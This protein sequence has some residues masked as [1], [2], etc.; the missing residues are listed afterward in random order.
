[1]RESRKLARSLLNIKDI[2]C[3]NIIKNVE[4]FYK[5]NGRTKKSFE[6]ILII[7]SLLNK[8][9]VEDLIKNVH[10]Y[11]I[12]FITQIQTERVNVEYIKWA[13]KNL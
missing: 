6:S 5:D 3:V 1:M 13:K 2:V 8:K 4:S 10:P 9:E 11:E 12:P 7:K